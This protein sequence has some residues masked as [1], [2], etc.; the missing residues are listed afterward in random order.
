[1]INHLW[2]KHFLKLKIIIIKMLDKIGILILCRYLDM[3]FN[4]DYDNIDK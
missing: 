1:M 2:I 4:Y 3:I